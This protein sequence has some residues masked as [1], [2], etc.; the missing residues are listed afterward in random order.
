MSVAHAYD[1]QVT[2]L[3]KGRHTGART[4][5][6]QVP[7]H[8]RTFARYTYGYHSYKTTKSQRQL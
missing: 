5:A 7:K 3:W 8:V 1:L 2:I 4:L 6:G